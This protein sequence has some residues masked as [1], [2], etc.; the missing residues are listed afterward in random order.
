MAKPVT[1]VKVPVDLR[2]RIVA[3]ARARQQTVAAFLDSILDEWERQQRFQAVRS[4]Y[5]NLTEEQ[6]G[7]YTAETEAW[8]SIETEPPA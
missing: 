3:D 7:D 4:A 6:R 5:A 2:D 8:A 1:S